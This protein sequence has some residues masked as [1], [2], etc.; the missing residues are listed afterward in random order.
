MNE[1][2]ICASNFYN[3]NKVHPHQ[4]KNIQIGFITCGRRHHNCIVTFAQIVGFPYSEESSVI[5]D[6]EIQGFLTISNRF[7][8]RFEAYEIALKENQI[9][10][11]KDLIEGKLFS[12]NLY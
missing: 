4:P 5:Q 12:E 1:R 7:V 11:T 10:N 2:I 6:T 3:D 8:D 9:V